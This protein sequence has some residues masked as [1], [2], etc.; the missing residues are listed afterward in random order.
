MKQKTEGARNIHKPA[1]M[2]YYYYVVVD[3]NKTASEAMSIKTALGSK[4][5]TLSYELFVNWG[6]RA[7]STVKVHV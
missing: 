3:V 2:E 7:F 5:V 4:L 6:L 1:V